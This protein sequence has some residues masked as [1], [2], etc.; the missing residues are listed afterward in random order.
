MQFADAIETCAVTTVAPPDIRL[1]SSN[2]FF[3]LVLVELLKCSHMACRFWGK[4]VPFFPLE[5]DD[6]IA[7]DGIVH[8]VAIVIPIHP[9]VVE[10]NLHVI[11][12]AGLNKG[13]DQAF[14]VE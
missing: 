7:T 11:F 14:A 3:D 5:I 8:V 6:S 9:R 2:K 13:G 1:E 10:P 12:M 4:L